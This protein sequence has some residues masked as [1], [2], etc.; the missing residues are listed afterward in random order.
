[1]FGMTDIHLQLQIVNESLVDVI[2]KGAQYNT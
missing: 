1:M 2:K